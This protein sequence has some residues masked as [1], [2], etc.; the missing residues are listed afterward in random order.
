MSEGLNQWDFVVAAFVI[1][2]AGTVL[3]IGWAL[4]AMRRAESRRD[5]ARG[6]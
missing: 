3:M 6:K 2:V 5:K 4:V 1:G